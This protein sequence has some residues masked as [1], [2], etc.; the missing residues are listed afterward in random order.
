M[1]FGI[2]GIRA[3]AVSSRPQALS[4][5]FTASGSAS[6]GTMHF[7]FGAKDGAVDLDEIRVVDLDDGRDVIPLC[8]FEGGPAEF[9][10]DWTVWPPGQQNTVGKVEVKPGWGETA[11]RGCTWN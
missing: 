8:T 7:R 11:R 2:P 5:E 6:T 3:L 9:A 1:F 4:F 10:S